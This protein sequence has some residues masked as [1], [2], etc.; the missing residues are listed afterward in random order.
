M[1]YVDAEDLITEDE[2]Q[3]I[4][5][6][7][8]FDQVPLPEN[9]EEVLTRWLV[10]NHSE[11]IVVVDVRNAGRNA[12]QCVVVNHGERWR[13]NVNW[14]RG[15]WVVANKELINDGYF[16]VTGYP[17]VATA[18][19]TGFLARLYPNWF[20]SQWIYSAIEVRNI[21]YFVFNRVVYRIGGS[22]YQAV[23]RTTH[24]VE[25]S[26]TLISWDRCRFLRVRDDY[27]YGIHYDWSYGLDSRFFFDYRVQPVVQVN[28]Q[29]V[30]VNVNVVVVDKTD[31]LC[32]Y[33]DGDNCL[34]CSGDYYADDHGRCVRI[35]DECEYWRESGICSRCS[36]GWVV[37]HE[38]RCV[39]Q[40]VSRNSR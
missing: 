27:G 31:L 19:A 40:T 30:E 29:P 12:Y 9:T 16:F 14:V 1:R 33:W 38:G 25:N 34:S 28:V 6:E 22:A 23:V 10:D 26:H 36:Y 39:A 20:N 37:G 18:S 3:G 5:Y 4:A 35:D 7:I 21:G 11:L 2:W 15:A 17:S 32:T 24:G 13:L 8:D